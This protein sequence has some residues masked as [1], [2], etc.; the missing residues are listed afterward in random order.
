VCHEYDAASSVA[1]KQSMQRPGLDVMPAGPSMQCG[2]ECDLP[3]L[4]AAPDV[5][6]RPVALHWL[7]P[8]VLSSDQ[9]PSQPKQASLSQTDVG[10]VTW[11]CG[12]LWYSCHCES[13][14]VVRQCGTNAVNAVG[15]HCKYAWYR[16]K[17]TC[18]NAA[19]CS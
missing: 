3:I 1:V 6:W 14:L 12:L 19:E 10:H 18:I 13:A 11:M 17:V 7:S 4:P 9:L 2:E 5:Y 16:G 15:R 8:A